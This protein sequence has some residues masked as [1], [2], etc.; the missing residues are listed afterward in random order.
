MPFLL[1]LFLTLTCLAEE[2]DAPFWQGL[3]GDRTATVSAALSWLLMAL[4]LAFARGIV[5]GVTRRL[6]TDP[7]RREQLLRRYGRLRTY[8]IFILIGAHTAAL[9]LLG[10]GWT[11]QQ[12]CGHGAKELPGAELFLLAPFLA[13]LVLS[14]VI[15]YDAERA[16]HASDECH[17]SEADAE[18]AKGLAAV[19]FK[20]SAETAQAERAAQAD[21][22][23]SRGAYVAFH[24]RQNLA[25]VF[26]PLVLL[27]LLKGL[28]RVVPE[29]K[30]AE[31]LTSVAA[32]VLSVSVF[33]GLPWLLRLV[34]GLRPLPPGPLRARLE[35]TA[36]RLHFR[37]SDIL[38]WNTHGGVANA[39]VAGVVP[40]VR[41]VLL[42]D[43]LMS[44][45][46]PDE[47][48]AVFG[49]E[50]GHVRHHHML[51]Y[52]GFLLASLGVIAAVLSWLALYL[53]FLDRVNTAW[54]ALPLVMMLGAYIFVV[55]G[56][57]S[58]R[59]ERQADVYGCRAV[60]CGRPDCRGHQGVIDLEPRD[61]ERPP[62]GLRSLLAAVRRSVRPLDGTTL[63]PTGI[64][65]FIEALEKV[66]RLNG[67]SRDKPGWLSSWQHSTIA[68][69]VEFLQ[70]V[71]RDPSLERRFQW[72]V[73]LVKLGLF[74]GLVGAL[75]GLLYAGVKEQ[76]AP[77]APPAA[78]QGTA[79]AVTPHTAGH[80]APLE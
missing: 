11:V 3:T 60:S 64:R 39:M 54:P 46:T 67:I 19:G 56:F 21:P 36:R 51:Y 50:V 66:A 8:H 71:L 65:T 15:F 80:T 77:V 41:Y 52:L 17:L 72:R 7:A 49:H 10:W 1:L 70:D 38:V 24:V 57:L 25:L 31:L 75:F 43:R 47:V 61:P 45:L 69:R 26:A 68:R 48:E 2:W 53:P 35:A 14:W 37:C 73:A 4:V 59:C 6:D 74:V 30:E 9:Y 28:R 18:R 32:I 58:R 33:V 62:V 78:T 44:E 27:I 55:F 42:T 16:I 22:F 40:W 20:D 5:A 34:L 63:C 76:E 12:F 23:W 79:D 29:T 13:T